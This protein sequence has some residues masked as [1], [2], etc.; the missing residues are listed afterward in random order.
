M[1]QCGQFFGTVVTLLKNAHVCS[2]SQG[3]QRIE[4]RE[5]YSTHWSDISDLWFLSMQSEYRAVLANSNCG[6]L[7]AITKSG[8]DRTQCGMHLQI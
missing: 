4:R 3:G 7:G 5:E 1:D 6:C 2:S 8:Q